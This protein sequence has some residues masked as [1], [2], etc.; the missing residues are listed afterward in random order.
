MLFFHSFFSLFFNFKK[1]TPAIIFEQNAVLKSRRQNSFKAAHNSTSFFLKQH[2][3]QMIYKMSNWNQFKSLRLSRLKIKGWVLLF[4][5]EFKGLPE[6]PSDPF[7]R[8]GG[9]GY[10]Q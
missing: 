8:T 2:L 1:I 5:F 9:K 6:T 7:R 10:L 3:I 4:S